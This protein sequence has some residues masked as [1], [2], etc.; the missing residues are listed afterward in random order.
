MDKAMPL[1]VEI[2]MNARTIS[3]IHIARWEEKGTEPDS[4]NGYKVVLGKEPKD[5]DDWEQGLDF[6]HRYGDGA[7]VCVM[8]AME[9]LNNSGAFFK[10]NPNK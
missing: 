6:K 7:E 8:K 5:N 4:V 3:T 2:K 9:A 1:F 10:I